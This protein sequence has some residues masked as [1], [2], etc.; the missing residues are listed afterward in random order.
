MYDK[1]RNS[2]SFFKAHNYNLNRKNPGEGL[3]FTASSSGKIEC[4][5]RFSDF[6]IDFSLFLIVFG[7]PTFFTGR[8]LQGAIF[9]KQIAFYFLMLLGVSAWFTN[10]A[11]RGE[12]K[13][14][15]TPLDIPIAIFWLSYALSTVFS[16][17]KWH[18]FW[19]FF[20]NPTH[21][22]LNITISFIFFYFV[23][24]NF[25]VRRLRVVLWAF[26][27]SGLTVLV[28]EL[29]K[30]GGML[31]SGFFKNSGWLQVV[32]TNEIG[33]VT[34]I[35]I[36][37]NILT[38]LSLAVFL[39]VKLNN[40][41]RFKKLF[42]QGIFL[43]IIIASFFLLA[44]F[45]P[46]VPWPGFLIGIGFFLIYIISGIVKVPKKIL[47]FPGFVFSCILIFMLLGNVFY[48][49]I[50]FVAENI[51][52]EINLDH[53]LSWHIAKNALSNHDLFLGS[54]PGTYGY[55]FSLFRPEN[56]NPDDLQNLRFYEGS[57]FLWEALPT[58]G[59]LGTFALILLV[60]SFISVAIYFLNK[61]KRKNSI[62]TLGFVS[63]A[64]TL[65]I[66][67]FL[68]RI[69]GSIVAFIFLMVTLTLGMMLEKKYTGDEYFKISLKVSP[70]HILTS[71]FLFLAAIAS[72]FLLSIFLGRILTADI[73]AGSAG[74]NKIISEEKSI[75]QILKAIE[76]NDREGRYYIFAGQQHMLLANNEFMRNGEKNPGIVEK[77]L[78]ESV[79][80]ASKGRDLMP[81]DVAA[82]EAL[83]EI[84]EN[85]SLYFSE[86]LDQA[87]S[88]YKDAI[89]LEPGNPSLYLRIGKI[90]IKQASLEKD[91]N[92]RAE[93]ISEAEEWFR[94]SVDKKNDLAEAQYQWGFAKGLLGKN[95]EAIES[96]KKSIELDNTKP[97]YFLALANIYQTRG[98]EGD[99]EIAE[100]IYKNIISVKG[101]DVNTCLSLGL[102]YEKMDRFDD[103]SDQYKKIQILLGESNLATKEKIQKMIE[104]AD[105]STRNNLEKS[106]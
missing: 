2:L 77:Y 45:H 72:A 57:G 88:V 18:S 25:N 28:W 106:E 73:Y 3:E 103:A 35:A 96:L 81:K 5:R 101:D 37:L 22:L 90:K 24:S 91:E 43:A 38:I 4:I 69:D 87:V 98:G 20:G 29:L 34:G 56:F 55:D 97:D 47:W 16:V 83:A 66:D 99:Y 48:P 46:F 65:L 32:L 67:A 59:I 75:D 6:L 15:R 10:S 79:A 49:S 1:F 80:F 41:A 23:L 70:G 64:I 95:D 11:I 94:K 68:L 39:E 82:V 76:L 40:F 8:T 102:L 26:F 14:R 42:L 61:D 54:G 13:I 93:I 31:D 33:S 52:K 62:C 86:F 50:K 78:D 105:N 63:A 19:G 58:L 36:F 12:M 53:S 21:G 17:D 104:N 100:K 27:S 71:M 89:I 51:P 30:I 60:L 84:Y 92:K 74:A 7:I 85:K 44:I 9:E